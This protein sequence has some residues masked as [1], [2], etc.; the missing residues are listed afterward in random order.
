MSKVK[1]TRSQST[2]ASELRGLAMRSMMNEET[3]KG[4]IY[5]NIKDGA[6]VNGF[7]FC[8]RERIVSTQRKG[9]ASSLL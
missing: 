6:L 5:V 1:S 4:L 7:V 2:T 3:A 8:A 9:S